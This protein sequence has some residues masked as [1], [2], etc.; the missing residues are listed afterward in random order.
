[1]TIGKLDLANFGKNTER[2]TD[3]KENA[4]RRTKPITGRT[5]EE[6]TLKL[7]QDARNI[8]EGGKKIKHRR[9]NDSSICVFSMHSNVCRAWRV[10]IPVMNKKVASIKPQNQVQ[11]EIINSAE[12]A[13]PPRRTKQKQNQSVQVN[14]Q[15]KNDNAYCP[16]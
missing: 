6:I 15:Q 8:I 16:L 4:D 12:P 11:K 5:T 1:M 13:T 3:L 9:I 7:A 10:R 14:K 2:Q